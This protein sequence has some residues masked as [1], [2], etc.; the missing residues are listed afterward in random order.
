MGADFNIKHLIWI[1]PLS[2][3][4]VFV[5]VNVVLVI[6]HAIRTRR[7]QKRYQELYQGQNWSRWMSFVQDKNV[8]IKDMVIFG[9][10]DSG[11]YNMDFSEPR[12][13]NE[14]FSMARPWLFLP[15]VSGLIK[16][17]SKTQNRSLLEQCEIGV[18]DFDLR[19]KRATDGSWWLFHGFK[20]IR[21]S[22]ALSQLYAFSTQ[23]PSE[24]LFLHL[25][26]RE[27]ADTFNDSQRTEIDALFVPYY[28]LMVN[29]SL[30]TV[31][32]TLQEFIDSDRKWMVF[33]DSD[34]SSVNPIYYT[35][36]T[37]LGVWFN[38][39]D[40]KDQVKN[41]Q[42][43]LISTPVRSLRSDPYQFSW[44][45]TP[46]TKDVAIS[47]VSRFFFPAQ[48]SS[49]YRNVEVWND[50]MTDFLLKPENFQL[51]KDKVWSFRGDFIQENVLRTFIAAWNNVQFSS[52]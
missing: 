20:T 32:N 2:I 30:L 45:L 21:L 42:T 28:S 44:T 31:D 29:H 46:Q 9:T 19:I 15:L 26:I 50:T 43:E 16:A 5:V 12:L 41:L 24:I 17:W 23:N 52:T 27:S 40:L 22:Q 39:F 49:L 7:R 34:M 1:I 3:S 8:K 13:N 18:R 10:H 47:A 14:E 4:A 25:S 33:S 37:L 6:Y 36:Q 38:T 11:A 51:I 35:N 48:N